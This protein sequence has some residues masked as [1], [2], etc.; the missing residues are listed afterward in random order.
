MPSLPS[1]ALFDL[2]LR[3]LPGFFAAWIVNGL[4]PRRELTAFAR[5]IEALIF[6]GIVQVALIFASYTLF[7]VGHFHSFGRWTPEVQ[8]VWAYLLAAVLGLLIAYVSTNDSLHRHLRKWEFTKITSYP[9]QWFGLFRQHEEYVTLYLVD[10]R[11]IAGWPKDWPNFPDRGEFSL[12][13]AKW[14]TVD[15]DHETGEWI[16]IPLSSSDARF[17]VHAADVQFVEFMPFTENEEMEEATQ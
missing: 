15:V 10:G 4:V 8:M 2:L 6:T 17:V 11:R 5:V 16:R 12:L 1:S 13:N 7:T 3:L 9:S 14:I